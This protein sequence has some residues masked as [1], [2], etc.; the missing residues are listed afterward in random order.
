M[1]N[2]V[3][4]AK[5]SAYHMESIQLLAAIFIIMG[6]GIVSEISIRIGTFHELV[7]FGC[8]HWSGY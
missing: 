1:T 7:P 6:G 2:S 4:I 3:W 5:D 8:V